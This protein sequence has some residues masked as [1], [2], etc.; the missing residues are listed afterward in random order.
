MVKVSEVE[1]FVAIVAAP[2]TL[3]I[4]GGGTAAAMHA[5]NSDVSLNNKATIPSGLTPAGCAA[6][7][8][9]I[10][11]AVDVITLP[12]TAGKLKLVNVKLP[13]ASVVSMTAPRKVCPSPLPLALQ[14]A[15]EKNSMRKVVLAVLLSDPEISTLPPTIDV[16]VN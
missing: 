11:V 15:L 5:E 7:L 13:L 12:P 16:E 8:G 1:P 9:A 14:T 6:R 2:K 4:V 10:S 3:A